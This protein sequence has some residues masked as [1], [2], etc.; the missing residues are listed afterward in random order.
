MS[1][2]CG[3]GCKEE[4]TTILSET[5]R[6][7]VDREDVV[8]QPSQAA[9]QI[10]L[11]QW[12]GKIERMGMRARRTI[13]HARGLY[14]NALCPGITE[15]TSTCTE[16]HARRSAH[17][18][19]HIITGGHSAGPW[20]HGMR[21]PPSPPRHGAGKHLHA[22]IAAHVHSELESHAKHGPIVTDPAGKETRD[23]AEQHSMRQW[24]TSSTN[25]KRRSTMGHP[26]LKRAQL[27]D[28]SMC[29]G[30]GG[31]A[32]TPARYAL[33][34]PCALHFRG[35]TRR[36]HYSQSLSCVFE[37]QQTACTGLPA[38]ATCDRRKL[39]RL[40]NSKQVFAA[41]CPVVPAL[42]GAA[43]A[44][45]WPLDPIWLSQTD[46]HPCLLQQKGAL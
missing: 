33:L 26:G 39:A 44:T 34:A 32:R 31:E 1:S 18:H 41:P 28:Q 3:E 45:Q 23:L 27:G 12:A 6:Q 16:A 14:S 21:C 29:T 37:L 42:A 15:R 10:A 9:G 20:P 24:A 4:L 36:P 30:L 38:G 11:R 8:H 19:N 5:R 25:M 22:H 13:A 46:T 17:K 35:W 2:V 40:Y 43:A 7:L